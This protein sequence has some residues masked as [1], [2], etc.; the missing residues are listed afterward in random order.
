MTPKSSSTSEGPHIRPTAVATAPR[1]L[2]EAGDDELA[3]GACGGVFSRALS[4]K[5]DTKNEA[6]TSAV[7]GRRRGGFG[8]AL[9]SA[10][11][12]A[13]MLSPYGRWAERRGGAA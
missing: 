5:D 8:S 7:H 2:P 13:A 4:R 9:F 3:R 11:A 6:P 1:V 12:L 10:F